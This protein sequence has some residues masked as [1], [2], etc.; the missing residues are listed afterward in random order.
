MEKWEGPVA[1]LTWEN[2]K[3]LVSFVGEGE[4]T[5][6]KLGGRIRVVGTVGRILNEKE[7]KVCLI[8]Y[9]KEFVVSYKT[10]NQ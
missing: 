9:F 8:C 6:S 10:F 3:S 7:A 4:Q 2:D 1:F 5:G